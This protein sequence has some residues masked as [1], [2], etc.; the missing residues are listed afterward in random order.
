VTL[1][2]SPEVKRLLNQ[3]ADERIKIENAD[4]TIQ[5]AEHAAGREP[6]LEE[7][8]AQRERRA[9]SGYKKATYEITDAIRAQMS[10]ELAGGTPAP[11]P[12]VAAA[13]DR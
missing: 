11:Q 2:G 9:L 1:H 5:Q 12:D 13:L 4:I 3:W 8:E 10:A 6:E 7:E